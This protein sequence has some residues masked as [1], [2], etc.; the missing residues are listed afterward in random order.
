MIFG[1]STQE[2]PYGL[3]CPRNATRGLQ[4]VLQAHIMKYLLFDC[5]SREKSL[6][7]DVSVTRVIPRVPFVVN[8]LLHPP[9]LLLLLLLQHA[10][11]DR[12]AATGGALAVDGQHFVEHRGEAAC[13][14]GAARRDSPHPAQSH[15]FPGLG[16]GE[17]LLLRV[18]PA[19]RLADI[20]Q[21]IPLLRECCYC[22]VTARRDSVC[23]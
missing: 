11:A 15:I 13:G 17:T 10:E 5:R 19:G 23:V 22:K 1:L 3:R 8:I 21:A 2:L 6:P 20:P 14:G 9:S 18:Y 16:H 7:L 12:S 4:S